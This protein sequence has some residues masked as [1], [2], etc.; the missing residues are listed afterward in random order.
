M[1]RDDITHEEQCEQLENG[2]LHDHLS[3][4]YGVNNR[5]VL[6]GVHHFS[7]TECLPFDTMHVLLE[8]V[9][10]REIRFD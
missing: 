6:S 10:T 3:V 5:S 1:L 9:L 8:G 7:I 4:N 2:D